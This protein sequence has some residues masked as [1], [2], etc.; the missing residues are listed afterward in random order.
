MVKKGFYVSRLEKAEKMD[1]GVA[2]VDVHLE[3]GIYL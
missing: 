1:V 3:A 2:N